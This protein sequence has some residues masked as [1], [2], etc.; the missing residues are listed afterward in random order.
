MSLSI[1]V[2]VS[3]ISIGVVEV[4]M[5]EARR[6]TNLARALEA[7]A[8][9]EGALDRAALWL[10][11]NLRRIRA[12]GPGGWM[13][14]G[15]E[16]WRPCDERAP[17]SPC[18][19]A[20]SREQETFDSRWSRY[21]LPVRLFTPTESGAESTTTQVVARAEHPGAAM[22][23]FSTLHLIAEG[24]SRDGTAQARLRRSYQLL[25][26]IARVPDIPVTI[27][28]PTTGN[29][30]TQVFGAYAAD[31]DALRT[32][33]EI[34]D[35]CTS[36]GPQSQ[37]VVWITG[38]SCVLPSA[39]TVGTAEAPVVVVIER[40]LLRVE[41]SAEIHGILVLPRTGEAT[42]DPLDASEPSLIHG[43]L[44]ADREI[45]LLPGGLS[46]EYDPELLQR[47]AQLP[48]RLIEI[49]GSWTDHR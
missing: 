47:L 37:G 46:V 41:A 28:D 24:R 17:D 10:H 15:R 40:G 9:T 49:P 22:P 6:V 4:V 42:T 18:F 29:A 34:H 35:D 2:A 31:I 45:A 26:L 48:G 32:S 39:T 5:G 43:A 19:P 12:T 38:T 20:D 11:L 13:E 25:P 36:L 7:E 44:I 1:V 30:L 33:S 14:P 3:V 8:V 21:A 16:R 23:A 27:S